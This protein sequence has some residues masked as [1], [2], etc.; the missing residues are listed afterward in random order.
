V[1]ADEP[2]HEG[3]IIVGASEVPLMPRWADPERVR[4]LVPAQL[5]RGRYSYLQIVWPDGKGRFPWE[6]RFDKRRLRS[7][8]CLF[9]IGESDSQT[10]GPGTNIP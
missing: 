1:K 6:P 5:A 10:E 7:Q 8:A 3:V 2:A 4:L 9:D